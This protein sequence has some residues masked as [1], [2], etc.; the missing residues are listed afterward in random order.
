MTQ[1]NPKHKT[2]TLSI[3]LTAEEHARLEKDSAGLSFSDH[4]RTCLFGEN[5]Q[6]RRTRGKHPVKD[7]AL[8]SR[9]L[10]KLGASR[11]ANNLNQLAHAA[12]CGA[13][14]LNPELKSVL[15]QACADIQEIKALIMKALGLEL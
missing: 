13:L 14:I 11:I 10:A 7:H 2:Y 4:T 12:N 5:T 15:L 1:T 6:K 3:R 9:V 8:L